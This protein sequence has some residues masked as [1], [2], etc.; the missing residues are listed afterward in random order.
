MSAQLNQDRP[1]HSSAPELAGLEQSVAGE[2]AVRQRI[3][4]IVPRDGVRVD[5]EDAP[6][7]VRA[8]L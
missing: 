3:I 7:G 8:I 6:L 5:V 4:S 1:C 2:P